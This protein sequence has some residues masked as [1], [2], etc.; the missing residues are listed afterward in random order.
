MSPAIERILSGFCAKAQ[1]QQGSTGNICILS[2]ACIESI[3]REKTTACSDFWHSLYTAKRLN[4]PQY[5]QVLAAVYQVA[6]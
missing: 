4:A 2:I 1:K 5:A 6:K 3:S